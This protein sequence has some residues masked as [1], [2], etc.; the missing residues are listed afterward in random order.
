[1][2]LFDWF[3]SKR[4]TIPDSLWAQTIGALPTPSEPTSS[5]CDDWRTTATVK[6][7]LAGGYCLRAPAQGPCGYANICEHCPSFHT[8]TS[9][10]PVLTAQRD[11]AAAVAAAMRLSSCRV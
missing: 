10:L 2:G 4:A 11:D 9:Y 8:T 5:A 3:G 1:M 7:A 6:T